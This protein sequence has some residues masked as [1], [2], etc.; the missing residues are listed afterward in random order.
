MVTST[1]CPFVNPAIDKPVRGISCLR[2]GNG[3]VSKRVRPTAL[4]RQNSREA[5]S[6]TIASSRDRRMLLACWSGTYKSSV[7]RIAASIGSVRRPYV[8]HNQMRSDCKTRCSNSVTSLNHEILQIKILPISHVTR[9]ERTRISEEWI[10]SL[11][12]NFS[13]FFCSNENSR[14]IAKALSE[15]IYIVSFCSM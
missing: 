6:R 14:D 8:I 2:N 13:F 7:N 11:S 4:P 15:I 9:W 1:L 10:K 5:H 3:R 12:L